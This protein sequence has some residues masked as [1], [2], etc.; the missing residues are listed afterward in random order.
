MPRRDEKHKGFIPRLCYYLP[1]KRGRLNN[2]GGYNELSS[3]THDRCGPIPFSELS[4]LKSL[5]VYDHSSMYEVLETISELGRRILERPDKCVGDVSVV[6]DG[7]WQV[8]GIYT[9]RS[10]SFKDEDWP[11]VKN[12]DNYSDE[13]WYLGVSDVYFAPNAVKTITWIRNV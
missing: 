2:L 6:S 4:D 7:T 5:N 11:M 13:Y 9:N 12:P 3:D 10:S 8:Y 1:I